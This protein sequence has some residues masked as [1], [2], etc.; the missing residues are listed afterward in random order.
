[1]LQ[2]I[3]D[4]LE[5]QKWLTYVVL[6]TLAVIF[7]AWGAYGIVN[8]STSGTSYAAE[9]GGQTVSVTDARSA[10]QREQQQFG[11]VDLPAPQKEMLQNQLLDQMVR[12][13]I[14][15]DRMHSLGYRISDSDIHQYIRQ[16]PQFQ[17]AGQYNP[18][19]AREILARNGVSE[20]TYESQVRSDLQ[21]RQLENAF[22]I[23]EFLTPDELTRMHALESE[24]REVRFATVPAA[25]Y[26]AETPVD[27]AAVQAYY[28]AHEKSY[29]TLESAHLQYAELRL[30]A[31]AAQLTVSDAD[32]KAA[33]EKNKTTY[34]EPEK[35]HAAH[36]LITD[37]KDDAAAKKLADEV[38]AKAKAGEDFGELAKKYSKD[39]GS[40]DKGGVLD[41]A[42]RSS[43][44][45][46]EF[47]D[48]AFSMSPGEI[49][50]PVK[51]QYGYHIIKLL[52]VEAGK[53]RTFE[54]AKP[55]I[56]ADL[57]RNRATDHFGEIQEQLQQRLEQAGG[58]ASLDA[59]AKEFNLQTGDVPD[60]VRGSGGGALGAAQPVQD[61]VFGDSAVATGHIGGPVVLGEDRL[62]IVKVVDHTMPH[63]KPLAEVH[64]SI[65]TQ[66]R[67]DH[68]QQASS[69]AAEE[70]V[71]KLNAGTSFDDVAKGLGVA[72]EPA[73]FVGRNDPSVPTEV[74]TLA[75]NVP[76][77][78]AGKT[79]YR[80]ARLQDGGA[81]IVAVSAVRSEPTA[82]Q[83]KQAE[84]SRTQEASERHAA[85][86]F[87][88]YVDELGR[89]TVVKKNLKAFE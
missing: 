66:L 52:E 49:H 17:V 6:G 77:P 53:T 25:K 69:K 71:A 22:L 26:E 7:A 81:A 84:A 29:M 8:L 87:S 36:I 11:G 55:E 76:R 35:R 45:A 21:T 34:V 68:G 78:A 58:N 12:Q 72:A 80:T 43:F 56:E 28:K 79:A 19:V 37:E 5:K 83:D 89:T 67:K 50:A 88:A 65:V 47:S 51:T 82:A 10:W 14:L 1:M 59:L 16:V 31:V 41:W 32:L 20:D 86:G 18:D 15:I 24:Q 48:A 38:Y 33:Y 63:A 54:E 61:L 60:F 3:R 27:D 30:D 23:S 46:P 62:A 42:D 64:D 70:G 85:A 39:P 73:K 44:V 57:K 75:F 4:G 74:R 40:A 9:A 13:L 2:R